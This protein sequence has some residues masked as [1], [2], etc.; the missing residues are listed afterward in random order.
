M[1]DILKGTSIWKNFNL[2]PFKLQVV[3]CSSHFILSS[4]KQLIMW[5]LSAHFKFI[6]YEYNN[7][8]TEIGTII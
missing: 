2:V 8:V 6:R 7:I 1:F 5:H 4:Q 3:K